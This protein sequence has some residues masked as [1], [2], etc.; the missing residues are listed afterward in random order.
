MN[1]A[2]LL[3]GTAVAVVVL[4]STATTEARWSDSAQLSSAS[5]SSGKLSLLN[6]SSTTQVSSY[7][8]TELSAANLAPGNGVQAPLVLSNDGDAAVGYRLLQAAPG[9][10]S[11]L[12]DYLQVGV[13]AVDAA[14][15]CPAG[16]KTLQDS[17]PED[18]L[19]SGGLGTALDGASRS[20]AVGETQALCVQVELHDAVPAGVQDSSTYITFT[21][22]AE[23]T[24]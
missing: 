21:F 16:P 20:L 24:S 3:L 19:Y 22:H 6:G 9:T 18:V 17:G 7:S 1:K 8:F 13:V 10:T 4:G 15:E 11:E 14:S 5:L 12:P 23:M 2:L